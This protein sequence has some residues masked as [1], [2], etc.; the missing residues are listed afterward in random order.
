M[1][2]SAWTSRIAVA[3]EWNRVV[4]YCS[5]ALKLIGAWAIETLLFFKGTNNKMRSI[6]PLFVEYRGVTSCFPI[7]MGKSYGVAERINFVFPLM[8]FLLHCCQVFF[9]FAAGWSKIECIRI[10]I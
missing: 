8:Q 5:F 6:P 9:P 2:H 10:W 4:C 1:N 7:A 3:S